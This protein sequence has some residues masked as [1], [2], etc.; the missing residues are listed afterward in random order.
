MALHLA[1]GLQS[2]KPQSFRGLE[3]KAKVSHGG[4]HEQRLL[5]G[6]SKGERHAGHLKD[7]LVED[8]LNQNHAVFCVEARV[9]LGLRE[10]QL[11]VAVHILEEVLSL[12]D[13]AQHPK[14]DPGF[15]F[16]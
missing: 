7:I 3:V 10:I 16:R 8:T 2:L 12:F 5:S 15:I 1:T 11:D 9:D 13:A 6:F 4:V 14:H